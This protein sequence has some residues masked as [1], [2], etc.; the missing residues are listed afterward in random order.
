[1]TLK[2]AND[3]VAGIIAAGKTDDERAHGEE[4]R[5]Y[6]DVLR[7]IAKHGDPPSASLAETVLQTQSANF[8]RWCA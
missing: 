4:D 1:M 2:E 5:L 6:E 7:H 8:A 3:R